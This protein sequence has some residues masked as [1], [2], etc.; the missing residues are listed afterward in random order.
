M[1]N[2]TRPQMLLTQFFPPTHNFLSPVVVT[3][4]M[5]PFF[6][7]GAFRAGHFV[8][9]LLGVLLALFF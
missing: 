3:K 9:C 1:G 4:F 6:I 2:K 5:L 8:V 7:E